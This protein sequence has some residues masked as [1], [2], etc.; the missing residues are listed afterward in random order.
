MIPVPW[1]RERLGCDWL[2]G[3]EWR[4][5]NNW[6][7]VWTTLLL[8]LS[9]FVCFQLW[10]GLSHVSNCSDT[11]SPPATNILWP[12]Y[13]ERLLCLLP[14]DPLKQMLPFQIVL[15]FALLI[16]ESGLSFAYKPQLKK[17]KPTLL[18]RGRPFTAYFNISHL[19]FLSSVASVCMFTLSGF[20]SILMFSSFPIFLW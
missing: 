2:L 16:L 9:F 19:L 18:L 7:I 3:P 5:L 4:C 1:P 17:P 11:E 10:F 6:I 13:K 20:D 14:R 12:W 15:K 8:F